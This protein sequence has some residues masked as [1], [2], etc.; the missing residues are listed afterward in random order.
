MESSSRS[1]ARR[2]GNSGHSPPFPP[3]TS[4]AFESPSKSLSLST[5]SAIALPES[6]PAQ[7]PRRN[8][9]F[10]N[11]YPAS[12]LM[13]GSPHNL[14]RSSS[15]IGQNSRSATPTLDKKTSVSS[16]QGGSG[17]PSSRPISRRSSS[18]VFPSS[19]SAS[20]PRSS[21]G[22]FSELP[23][24]PVVTAASVA[25]QC[26]EKELELHK[27]SSA[28]PSGSTVVI[29]QDACFAH[30]YSRPRTSRAS[31]ST[32]VERPERI[33]A[34]IVGISAAYV[35]LGGRYTAGKVPLHPKQHSRNVRSL[36]F[37]IQKSTRA[38]S[39]DSH[40]VTA[41]HG[42]EWMQEL[43]SMCKSAASKLALNGK[44][45]VR[46]DQPIKAANE[47]RPKLHEGDLYLCK[48]SLDALEGCIGAVYDGVD[49]IFARSE[50][51]SN[52]KRAFV[53]IRPPGHHCSSSFPSGFCWLNNVHVGIAYAA[54]EHGLTH[55]AIIDFDLHHGDGSQSI[56]W[57]HNTKASQLPKNASAAKKSTI[58]YFSIH[59]INSYPCEMGDEEKIKNASLCIENAHGQTIWNVHLQP[60][61]HD[62]EFWELYEQRY[63]IL[64]EKTRA[65]LK[66][67]AS[68]LSNTPN[69]PP[70]KAAIFLSAGFDASEW[71]GAGMQRHKVNVPT[72]FY[73]KLT[74]DIVSLAEEEGLAVDGRILSVLEGG[75]SNRALSSGVMSHISGLAGKDLLVN[76]RIDEPHARLGAEMSQIT[77]SFQALDLDVNPSYNPSWWSLKNL[78]E[79]EGLTDPPPA[80]L[81]TKKNRTSAPTYTTPTRSFTAKI[82]SSPKIHRVASFNGLNRGPG[83]PVSRP[84][85]PP[86]PEISWAV[87]A[88]QLSQLLIPSDR[89]TKSCRPEE[90]SVE[91]SRA[92]RKERRVSI[93]TSNEPEP[94][95]TNGK[96]QLRDRRTKLPNYS[97]EGV[98]DKKPSDRRRTLAG[99]D[100]IQ[101]TSINGEI[102]GV[103][104]RTR[105]RSS[106][107][108]TL[109]STIQ[110]DSVTATNPIRSRHASSSRA[111][112]PGARTPSL[113]PLIA[114]PSA[115]IAGAKKI[116]P[117]AGKEFAK[118]RTTKRRETTGGGPAANSQPVVAKANGDF[119]ELAT[120]MKK[121]TIKLK[122]PSREEHDARAKKETVEKKSAV[123]APRKPAVPK[124][125][126]TNVP[127]KI[128]PK[129]K[130][131]ATKS[132]DSAPAP[133]PAT[134]T[135]DIPSVAAVASEL[136]QTVE[137]SVQFI[138]FDPPKPTPHSPI[139]Q[140]PLV[141][142]PPNTDTPQEMRH[143][144]LPSFTSTSPIPFGQRLGMLPPDQ[145]Q[146]PLQSSAA[147]RGDDQAM[148][149]NNKDAVSGASAGSSAEIWKV[150][151]SPIKRKDAV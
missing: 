119:D 24:A 50:P 137:S 14:Q 41:V 82:A 148:E 64:L 49:G 128:S 3:T 102:S 29:L 110:E 121:M 132:T 141:W 81:V 143:S 34:S 134:F 94:E 84:P 123:R 71:E 35:R 93:G 124:V 133:A 23:E 101:K 142:L 12:P 136:P 120:S 88:H 57:K 17:I 92:A 31:L 39:L 38:V 151:D 68:Q 79:L 106:A 66:A 114:A 116:R 33:H 73:A 11:Q 65:F 104:S 21:M 43:T 125:P 98:V 37:R 48:E 145:K 130:E 30:R 75:Y 112:S 1:P 105:R 74:S 100:L 27:P 5:A 146:A 51:D 42:V 135:S 131:P 58:G 8:W 2:R 18:S 140:K 77:K 115:K 6:S 53:C 117:T 95:A 147:L 36:P 76:D 80:P 70:P 54:M 87:A 78:E 109:A 63:S 126:K 107:A 40:A 56:A 91:A 10:T 129:V 72:D 7:S 60:W 138:P 150:P 9:P 19:P 149:I 139:C 118:P 44:E 90:L 13:N 103:A 22:N 45:L 89:E 99:P 28:K 122:F 113:P 25:K 96:R 55:A 69:S 67:Q 108:S 26:L 86:P 46:P 32:I 111:S 83:S 85:S 52:P 62:V 61:K 59:D 16:L 20:R 144:N 15:T 97:L 4:A 47:E 127:R